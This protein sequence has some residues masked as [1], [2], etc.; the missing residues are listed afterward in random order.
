[1]EIYRTWPEFQDK[2]SGLGIIKSLRY[3]LKTDAITV[4]NVEAE[5]AVG[6]EVVNN[7]DGRF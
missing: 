2:E 1:M 5:A 4:I 7:G 3:R 6:L